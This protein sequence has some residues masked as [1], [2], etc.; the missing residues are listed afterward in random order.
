MRSLPFEKKIQFPNKCMFQFLDS[1]P[2]SFLPILT[3]SLQ[4]VYFLKNTE[5]TKVQNKMDDLKNNPCPWNSQIIWKV[6]D[7]ALYSPC[8]WLHK[9]MS[10]ALWSGQR[11]L[12]THIRTEINSWWCGGFGFILPDATDGRNL[13]LLGYYTWK[14]L[15]KH[16]SVDSFESLS[17]AL[18]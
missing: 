14:L 15:Q 8:P 2:L 4:Q 9:S 11:P 18:P 7:A 17:I 1:L 16:L 6:S 5:M 10:G 12:S 13:V 3:H